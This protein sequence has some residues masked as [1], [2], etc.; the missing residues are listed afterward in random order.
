MIAKPVA[1]IAAAIALVGSLWFTFKPQRTELQ[2]Q[3]PVV[4]LIPA[5]SSP[6]NRL[7]ELGLKNGRLVSGPVVLQVK[8][9]D[10]ITLKIASNN[11]DELHVHGYDLRLRIKPEEVVNLDFTANRTGRFDLELHRA[12]AELGVLEVYPQ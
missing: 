8:A 11:S 1:F 7:F 3:A 12:H 6:G 10:R 5:A 9:G 4:G 2:A